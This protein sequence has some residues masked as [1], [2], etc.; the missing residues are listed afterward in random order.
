MNSCVL[1]ASALL[2]LLQ[3]EPGA[4]RV[5][6]ALPGAVISS[7]NFAEVFGKLAE[8]GMPPDLIRDTLDSLDVNVQPFEKNLACVVGELRPATK[9]LGLSLG[10]RACLAL[11]QELQI[12]ALTADRAWQ[13]IEMATPAVELV[14]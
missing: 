6:D 3:D 8:N 1:D 9:A 11:A 5:T 4:D 2:A 10:D 13:E 7:V 12:P 14:R